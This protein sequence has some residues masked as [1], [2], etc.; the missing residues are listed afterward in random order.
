[1]SY[2]EKGLVMPDTPEEKARKRKIFEELVRLS[3]EA[4][5]YEDEATPEEIVSQIKQIRKEMAEEGK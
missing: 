1:M 2:G 4:G 3:E 5:L